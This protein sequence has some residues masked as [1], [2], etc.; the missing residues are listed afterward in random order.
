MSDPSFPQLPEK[1]GK[2]V[3]Q[4]PSTKTI[5]EGGPERDSL[6]VLLGG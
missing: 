1:Q 2:P 3:E 6:Y 4:V 5:V